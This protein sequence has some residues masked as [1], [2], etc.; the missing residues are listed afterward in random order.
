[1]SFPCPKCKDDQQPHWFTPSAQ[2]MEG[3]E[4]RCAK[5]GT[6]LLLLLGQVTAVHIPPPSGGGGRSALPPASPGR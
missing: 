5:C 4:W 1:M 2:E 6:L 3:R